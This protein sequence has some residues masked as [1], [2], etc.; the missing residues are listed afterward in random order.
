M[1]SI[2]VCGWEMRLI[3]VVVVVA[4]TGGDCRTRTELGGILMC[5]SLY[6]MS[7]V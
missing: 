1:G 5:E 6:S 3:G 2:I 4:G 7:F